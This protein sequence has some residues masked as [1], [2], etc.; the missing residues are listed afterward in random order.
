[1]LGFFKVFETTSPSRDVWGDFNG[2]MASSLLVNLN[3]M[4]K[5]EMGDCEGRFKAL[6]TDPTITINNKGVNQFEI[7]SYQRFI[8]TTNKEDPI[9][10]TN[11]D[12]RT[13]IIRSSDEKIGDKEY[14]N[15]I[16]E[17]LDDINVIRT[18]YDYFK[19]ISGMENFGSIPKPQTEYQNNLKQLYRSPIEMWLEDFTRR[20][21]LLNKEKVERLGAE[22]FADFE[23]WRRNNNIRFDTTVSKLGSSLLNV[24]IVGGVEKGR[25]T[26]KGWTKIFNISVL[27]SHFGIGSL[28]NYAYNTEE[29]TDGGPSRSDS[30]SV[31]T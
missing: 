31:D 8:I 25:H 7:Q 28:V 15:K 23:D 2:M 21:S 9:K 30:E 14:F 5:K 20:Y 6:A 13:I 29:L 24:Q 27:K 12:R 16:N 22:T 19:S 10:T 4:S 26:N 18:C 11:D 1:M 3:E 17:Y